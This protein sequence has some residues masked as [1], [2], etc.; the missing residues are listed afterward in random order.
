MVDS[1]RRLVPPVGLRKLSDREIEELINALHDEPFVTDVF[2]GVQQWFYLSFI[3][4]FLFY[5]IYCIV[6]RC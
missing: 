3:I 5:S 1:I 6:R 2:S 4:F